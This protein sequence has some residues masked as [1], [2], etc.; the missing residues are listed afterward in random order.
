MSS[1]KTA[2][3][4]ET[5]KSK[6]YT[7]NA[8]VSSNYEN[9]I[10]QRIGHLKS[11]LHE[12]IIFVQNFL[13]VRVE[14]AVLV[15]CHDVPKQKNMSSL[16]FFFRAKA[17]NKSIR[18]ILKASKNFGIHL[19][20][21]EATVKN[22]LPVFRGSHQHT[23]NARTFSMGLSVLLR[24]SI[25][26][27]IKSFLSQVIRHRLLSVFSITYAYDL[28]GSQPCGSSLSRWYRSVILDG[29]RLS[30]R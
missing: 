21:I 19:E 1:T 23:R 5:S 30:A 13:L 28:F 4:I 10:P 15:E 22:K 12:I 25:M 14:T 26:P 29:H 16:K 3:K 18:K 27:I 17:G 7:L 11:E 9:Y 20:F 24:Y 8:S 6:I 2:K